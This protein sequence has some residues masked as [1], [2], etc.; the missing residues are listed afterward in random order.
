M[1]TLFVAMA[2]VLICTAGVQAQNVSSDSIY[3]QYLECKAQQ[4][5]ERR[6]REAEQRRQEQPRMCKNPCTGQMQSCEMVSNYPCK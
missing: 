3:G 2:L 4:D 6:Q 1:K 5:A